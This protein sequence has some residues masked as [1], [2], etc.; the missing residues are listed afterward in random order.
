MPTIYY[1]AKIINIIITSIILVI[2]IKVNIP[3]QHTH[4]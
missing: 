2:I 3:Q 1:F 4:S